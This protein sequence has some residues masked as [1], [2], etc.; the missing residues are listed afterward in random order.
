MPW[1]FCGKH[2]SYQERPMESL[3]CPAC[4]KEEEKADLERQVDIVIKR[5]V[6]HLDLIVS[7]ILIA[8]GKK[9]A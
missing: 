2:K 1:A 6:P 7:R 8:M 4:K 5:L 3:D 9:A